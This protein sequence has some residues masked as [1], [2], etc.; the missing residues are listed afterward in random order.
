MDVIKRFLNSTVT[1]SDLLADG[2]V[3]I[4]ICNNEKVLGTAGYRSKPDD[5]VNIHMIFKPCCGRVTRLSK[6]DYDRT[7]RTTKDLT[8]MKPVEGG[9]VYQCES[10][11]GGW[12]PIE[13]GVL[14]GFNVYATVMLGDEEHLPIP[15]GSVP[16]LLDQKLRCI[17]LTRDPKERYEVVAVGGLAE[18][19]DDH[20]IVKTDHGAEW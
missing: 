18:Q 7:K 4:A 1:I 12:A 3:V 2:F 20:L 15:N 10:R 17:V 19:R 8:R 16:P 13:N 14:P 5:L 11:I 9:P 6:E